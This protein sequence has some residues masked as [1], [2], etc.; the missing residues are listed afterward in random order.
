MARHLRGTLL[1]HAH[2]RRQHGDLAVRQN[3]HPIQKPE[4][5]EA[6]R[7][8]TC[9]CKR[10]GRFE[11]LGCRRNR[12]VLHENPTRRTDFPPSRRHRP[13]SR[14]SCR[15]GL[16]ET[17]LSG[18]G[19][20]WEDAERPCSPNR[21]TH[22]N[23][24]LLSH[25]GTSVDLHCPLTKRCRVD[26]PRNFAGVER[27]SKPRKPLPINYQPQLQPSA[28]LW[29]HHRSPDHERHEKEVG[30]LILWFVTP[31]QFVQVPGVAWNT[32]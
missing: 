22:V 20:L 13:S 21:S 5:V 9:D 4:L 28:Y 3:H 12:E 8:D 6:C 17:H 19:N 1:L 18:I 31:L 27:L 32:S 25:I 15:A 26:I 7:I 16:G 11:T 30:L 2:P 23:L 24:N 29:A 10:Q 14:Y